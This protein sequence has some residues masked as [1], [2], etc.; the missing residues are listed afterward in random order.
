MTRLTR[1]LLRL[2]SVQAMVIL[3]LTAALVWLVQLLTLFDLVTAKGQNLFT[4]A[5]QAALATTPLARG[6]V[7]VCM[8]IGLARA[9]TALQETRE[10]HT[11]HAARRT[12]AEVAAILWFAAGGAV[13]ALG[14]A[15]FV[16]PWAQR[17]LSVWSGNI[18]ADL[19]GR[20]LMPGRFTQAVPGVVMEIGGRNPDGTI[21]DFF[22]DDRRDPAVRRT[23]VAKTAVIV[24]DDKGFGLSLSD[25]SVQNVTKAGGFSE[26]AFNRYEIGL[27]RLTEPLEVRDPL[28]QADSLSLVEMLAGA[29]GDTDAIWQHLNTRL[30]EGLRVVALVLMAAVLA[31][32]P[33]GRRSRRFVPLELVVLVIAFVER[34]LD[35]M[36]SRAGPSGP[37]ATPV[38]LLCLGALVLAAR[39]TLPYLRARRAGAPA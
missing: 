17:T 26:I 6:I 27:D 23:Y 18:A 1:Y 25:G 15:N 38:S 4:L 7:S 29:K 10:L 19:V 31:A 32:F 5:G 3:A 12:P 16:E 13:L 9:L 8:G 20:A 24:S 35:G 28:L 33:H 2:F 14:M 30:A 34:V 36:V 22:A 39:L 11:I 37:F 21:S